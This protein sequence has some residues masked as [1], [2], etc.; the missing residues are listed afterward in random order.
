MPKPQFSASVIQQLPSPKAIA[1]AVMQSAR[2]PLFFSLADCDLLARQ[3]GDA[4]LSPQRK[5][6]T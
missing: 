5:G 6:A 2:L 3:V 4:P 1:L